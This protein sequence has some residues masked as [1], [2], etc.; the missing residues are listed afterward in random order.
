MYVLN[1]QKAPAF[2]T[3]KRFYAKQNPPPNEGRWVLN[4]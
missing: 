3:Y 1:V 2:Q 4:P